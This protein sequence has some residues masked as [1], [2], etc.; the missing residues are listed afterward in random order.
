LHLQGDITRTIDLVT[1]EIDEISEKNQTEKAD[2]MKCFRDPPELFVFLSQ[3]VLLQPSPDRDSMT[4][5]RKRFY[6]LNIYPS[7]E[8]LSDLL[9][10]PLGFAPTLLVQQ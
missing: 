7:C 3:R 5:F 9:V 2:N 1:P 8:P 10:V 4:R 6:S